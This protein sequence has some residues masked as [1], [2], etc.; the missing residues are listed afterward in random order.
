[1]SSS[2]LHTFSPVACSPGARWRRAP[3]RPSLHA[4]RL[5]YKIPRDG[6]H[7]GDM[8]MPPETATP[9]RDRYRTRG[10]VSR[11][12]N[13]AQPATKPGTAS[14]AVG[15][16]RDELVGE[17]NQTQVEDGQLGIPPQFGTCGGN[18]FVGTPTHG[19]GELARA[20]QYAQPGMSDSILGSVS[21][22]LTRP[23]ANHL[24]AA[25]VPFDPGEDPGRSPESVA[26]TALIHNCGRRAAERQ[27][28]D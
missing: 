24:P 10:M 13:D 6:V 25:S 3:D 16:R 17:F 14:R 12:G 28:A 19:T 23:H 4:K 26:S 8:S 11:R 9:R 15:L 5:E 7:C 2:R 21:I 20:N 18:G 1:M 27:W 22:R